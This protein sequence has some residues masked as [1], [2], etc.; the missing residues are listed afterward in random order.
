M[1]RYLKGVD[2]S[3]DGAYDAGYYFCY[4]FEAPANRGSVAVKRGNTARDTYWK[5]YA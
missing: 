4:H 5:K 2:N 1:L 3:A